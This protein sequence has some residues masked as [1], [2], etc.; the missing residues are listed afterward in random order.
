MTTLN[1]ISG[2]QYIALETFRKN[3]TG[4]VTPVWQTPENGKLYVWTEANSWKVKRIRNN[5]RVRVA[6]SDARGTPDSDWVE[7]QASV[8]ESEAIFRAQNGR[9]VAKYGLFF[10]FFQLVY[11]LRGR[12]AAVLEIS[13]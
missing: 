4:V 10:R 3:G 6:A 8:L 7:A 11:K 5:G 1:E 2:A 13:A 12:K 9:M